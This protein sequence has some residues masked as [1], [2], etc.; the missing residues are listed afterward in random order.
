MTALPIK[1]PSG[2]PSNKTEEIA[3]EN[4]TKTTVSKTGKKI[5]LW[6]QRRKRTRRT[7]KREQAVQNKQQK[8]PVVMETEN[9]GPRHNLGAGVSLALLKSINM[10]FARYKLKI[11]TARRH[12]TSE[13]SN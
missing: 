13:K 8:R 11:L 7:N 6:K 9:F 5:P 10:P 1:P 4:V 3:M 12:K 2:N